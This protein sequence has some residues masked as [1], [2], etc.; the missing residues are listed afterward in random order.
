MAP[1]GRTAPQWPRH[2]W[3]VPCRARR[4]PESRPA[5]DFPA[6]R[7]CALRAVVGVTPGRPFR[8]RNVLSWQ[9]LVIGRAASARRFRGV[10][11][12]PRTSAARRPRDG[13]SRL[14]SAR[15]VPL[16]AKAGFDRDETCRRL[17]L[18]LSAAARKRGRAAR[19]VGAARRPLH[20]ASPWQRKSVPLARPWQRKNSPDKTV[21]EQVPRDKTVAAHEPSGQARGSAV[22]LAVPRQRTPALISHPSSF[23]RAPSPA[24]RGFK[25]VKVRR[26]EGKDK[27]KD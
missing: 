10:E 15:G 6:W 16:L 9:R 8:S 17:P 12:T 26:D 7:R 1:V 24:E 25:V 11:T 4:R 3:R 27:G 13:T 20:G 14:D 23:R 19:A 5:Q 18:S 22:T 21:A 2:S